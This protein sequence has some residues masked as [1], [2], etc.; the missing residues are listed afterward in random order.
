MLVKIRIHTIYFKWV[1]KIGS[2]VFFNERVVFAIYYAYAIICWCVHDYVVSQ[3]IDSAIM[4]CS[5]KILPMSNVILCNPKCFIEKGVMYTYHQPYRKL[6]FLHPIRHSLDSSCSNFLVF[7]S[8]FHGRCIPRFS[9]AS[10]HRIL[11]LPLI[12]L[13]VYH[14]QLV[15]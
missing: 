10:T 3:P 5:Q 2:S 14:S 1:N 13:Q 8:Y 7:V 11:S 4:Y 12:L 15:L 6:V 9:L